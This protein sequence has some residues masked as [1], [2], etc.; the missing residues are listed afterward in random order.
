MKEKIYRRRF[1]IGSTAAVSSAVLAPLAAAPPAAPTAYC[2]LVVD[3]MGAA[4]P[5]VTAYS[6]KKLA[7]Y[8]T[9]QVVWMVINNSVA[10]PANMTIQV[11]D[12]ID[13]TGSP[14]DPRDP[15][16]GTGPFPLPAMGDP[17]TMITATIKANATKTHYKYS[18]V[19][20]S[21][22][23]AAGKRVSGSDPEMDVVDVGIPVPLNRENKKAN[24]QG[25]QPNQ[26]K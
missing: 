22:R 11:R 8:Q 10:N 23:G 14:N 21:G 24:P 12:F 6:D 25:N 2:I 26:K 15:S 7:C 16:S 5:K 9:G 17:P 18:A 3:Q 13:K 20:Y 1:L 19:V 4:P